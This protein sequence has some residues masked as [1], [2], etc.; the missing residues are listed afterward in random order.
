[1]SDD[2]HYQWK[3]LVHYDPQRVDFTV[4]RDE[5]ARLRAGVS[6]QWK[7]CFL[8]SFSM[9]LPCLINGIAATP[10]PFRLTVGLFLD[11]L[12]GIIG[13]VLAIPFGIA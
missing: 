5:L 7:D 1:M 2:Q 6:N 11:Y 12:I 4:S 3:A 9:G 10:N 8:V 13:L